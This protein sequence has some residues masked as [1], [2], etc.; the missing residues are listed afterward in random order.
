MPLPET[1]RPL[2]AASLVASFALH[3]AVLSVAPLVR[4]DHP[5]EPPRVL[6]VLLSAVAPQEEEKDL[7]AE[8]PPPRPKPPPRVQPRPEATRAPAPSVPRPEPEPIIAP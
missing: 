2:F 7:R 4:D 1:E 6:S 8:P 3:A 5:L